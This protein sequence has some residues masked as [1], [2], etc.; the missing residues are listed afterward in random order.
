MK[1]TSEI[2]LQ[3]FLDFA[4]IGIIIFD[5]EFNINYVNESFFAFNLTAAFSKEDILGKSILS[6]KKIGFSSLSK[7]I[8]TLA[9]GESFESEL[10]KIK[11]LEGNELRIIAKAS[12]IFDEEIF[13]GGII[14]IEDLKSLT[15]ASDDKFSYDNLLKSLFPIAD[16]ALITNMNGEVILFSASEKLKFKQTLK[17]LRE[18]F[19]IESENAIKEMYEKLKEGNSNLQEVNLALGKLHEEL[20]VNVKI[21]PIN[22]I[23]SNTALVLIKDV[24]EELESKIALENEINELRRYQAITSSI[25]D[26]VIGINFNGEIRFW[27]ESS[28]KIFGFSRSQVYGK[29]ISI[30]FPSINEDY[31]QILRD[32]LTERKRWEGD[33]YVET[34]EGTKEIYDVRMG[35]TGDEESKSI[36]ILCSSVTERYLSEKELRQSEERFRNIVT[37]SREYICTLDLNGRI[38]YANPHFAQSF[39]YSEDE[40]Y[41]RYFTDLVDPEFLEDNKLEILPEKL[42]SFQLNEIPLVKQNGEIVFVLASFA[43]VKEQDGTPKYYIAV[44][45]DITEKKQA[46]KDLLLIKTVFEASQD[47]IAVTVNGTIILVNNSFIKMLGYQSE[48]DLVGGSFYEFIVDSDRERIENIFHDLEH[49]EV[50]INRIEFDLIKNDGSTFSVADSVAKYG[51]DENM[52]LVSVLRDVTIEKQNR[53][54]LLKSEERYRSI[55]ENIEE[56]LWTAEQRDGKLKVVL[57]TPAIKDITGFSSE[58]FLEDDKKWMKIIHPDDAETVMS[59]MKRLYSDPGRFSDA[60]QYRIINHDGNIVWLENKINIIRDDKGAIQKIYGLVSDISFKKKAE[61]ELKSSAENLKKLNEAKDR[62][63]SIISHDLRTPF[64]SIL[65]FTDYLLSEKDV[66]PEKQRTYIKLIQ[67]SSKS[68]LSLV[69]SLLDFTRIQT[70]RVRFEPERISAKNIIQKSINMLSGTTMQKKISLKSFVGDDVFV[71][72]DATLLLQVFNNLISNAIKFTNPGG[73][74]IITSQPNVAERG[75][76]FR[77][78]DNGIGIKQE[79]LGKLFNVDSKFTTPGTSGE[80]GSG[81][82]L[83]LVQ[84]IIEKHGG[85]ISVESELG[86][87]TEFI[88]TM[89]VSSMNIL[90]VDD[91]KTDRILYSKLIKNFLPNYQIVE[92]GE[93][94]EALKIIRK[95]PPAIV[96]TDHYMRGMGGYDLVKQIKL[97]EI[98]FKPPVIILSRDITLDISEEYAELGVEFVFQKPVNLKSFKEALERS[99]KK[100]IYY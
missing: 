70:G 63:L 83:S 15:S 46:E 10:K 59:K 56:S 95:S 19:G 91:S 20:L 12:S 85:K 1:T 18:I 8:R 60:F 48:D 7:E 42:I 45:T 51:V 81:L 68:M 94:T 99:L 76:E 52:F 90:L 57:Y 65:G 98:D 3:S 22:H 78:K 71:H 23:G 13:K 2:L 72:A 33:L 96:I 80:K 21:I 79:D 77:V 14:I 5:E 34:V 38:N 54:A 11:S 74:I 100:A 55:T 64:S 36:V 25:V 30:I 86:K 50:E 49:G 82:G 66:D 9:N 69:N 27:N 17:S 41:N 44:L 16:A 53:D 89:P 40:L 29:F 93:G 88:F 97:L 37:N 35:L 26:A 31:F 39:G 28:E 73:E 6:D 58:E 43:S 61:E 47:G 75:F 62:F 4:P 24:T 84:E 32:E 67:D 87:G 92:A